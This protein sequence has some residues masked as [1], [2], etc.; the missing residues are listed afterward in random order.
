P[1][2][3]VGVNLALERG[4]GRSAVPVRPAVVGA[5]VGIAGVVAALTFGAS[6]DRLVATP[7]RYGAAFDLTPDLPARDV[8]RAA[9]LPEVAGAGV[10]HVSST[11]VGGRQAD[12][13]SITVMKGHP[14]FTVLSGRIPSSP[15]EAA[16]GPD[17]FRRVG[18]RV[19]L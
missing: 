17:Q 4:R 5:V 10:V 2:A 15:G 13:Y 7:A 8:E 11:R 1:T 6:L 14:G 18:D 9:A 19:S 3:V 16:L 12:A